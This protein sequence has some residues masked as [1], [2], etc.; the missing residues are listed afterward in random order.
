MSETIPE[1]KQLKRLQ[2]LEKRL[3]KAEKRKLMDLV[4][5]ISKIQNELFPNYSLQERNTNFSE[6]YLEFGETLIPFLKENLK[7]LDLEFSVL[8]K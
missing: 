8:M 3:L 7:P 4:T 1:T 5:R 2:V 6:L